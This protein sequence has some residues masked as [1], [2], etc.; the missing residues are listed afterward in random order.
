MIIKFKSKELFPLKGDGYLKEGTN[1]V[2]DKI[3][4]IDNSI[5]KIVRIVKGGLEIVPYND[6]D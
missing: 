1:K 6:N 4:V 2:G 5:Y 3:R